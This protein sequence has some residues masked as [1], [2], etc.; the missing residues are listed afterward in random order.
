MNMHKEIKEAFGAVHA[1]EDV[2]ER[3]KQDLYQ[4]DLHENAEE[5][6]CQAAQAPKGRFLRYPL[7]AAAA[8]ALCVGCGLSLWSIQ[9]LE[10]PLKPA[11]TVPV[12]STT[13]PEET[14]EPTTEDP[15][16]WAVAEN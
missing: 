1:P 2:T 16:D 13:A 5:M 12:V 9:E 15:A 10:N 8:V 3:L 14:T 6:T 11:S 4:M 7:Y